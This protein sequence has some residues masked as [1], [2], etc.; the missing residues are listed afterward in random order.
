M[1]PE[2]AK[3]KPVMNKDGE[4]VSDQVMLALKDRLKSLDFIS[5]ATRSHARVL[6]K[7]ML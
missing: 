6:G 4:Q 5:R 2:G 1:H 3:K 7:R